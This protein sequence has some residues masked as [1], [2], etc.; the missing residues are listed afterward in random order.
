MQALHSHEH[1]NN[2]KLFQ[3]AS[4]KD[5]H[6]HTHTH[7]GTNADTQKHI[8]Y[9]TCKNRHIVVKWRR[10]TLKISKQKKESKMQKKREKFKE[11][12]SFRNVL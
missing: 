4:V 12:I 6:I 7:T 8:G 2:S 3:Q 1:L 11:D 9:H 5:T 10:K